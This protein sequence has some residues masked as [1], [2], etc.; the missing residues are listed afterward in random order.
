MVLPFWRSTRGPVPLSVLLSFPSSVYGF[1]SLDREHWM[2]LWQV[3]PKVDLELP[4]G[5]RLIFEGVWRPQHPKR[6]SLLVYHSDYVQLK[7]RVGLVAAVPKRVYD[8]TIEIGDRIEVDSRLVRWTGF[9]RT[10]FSPLQVFL[11]KNLREVRLNPKRE[12]SSNVTVC[13]LD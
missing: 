9:Y 7:S 12:H 11:P 13:C 5:C 8:E 2:P 1:A 3:A 10:G 4:E 6:T